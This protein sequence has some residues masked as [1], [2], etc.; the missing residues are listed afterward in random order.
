LAVAPFSARIPVAD[1]DDRRRIG[2]L[3]RFSSA[4]SPPNVVVSLHEAITMAAAGAA[5][6]AHSASISGLRFG[7]ATTPGLTQL[8]GPLGFGG[9][10]SERAARIEDRPKVDRNVLQSLLLYTSLSSMTTTVWPWPAIAGGEQGI[11]V[12]DGRQIGRS[13]DMVAQDTVVLRT[14]DVQGIGRK[15]LSDNHS[16]HRRSQ[17]RA[18]ICDPS[19]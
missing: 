6:L 11:Q 16:G 3:T 12:V 13:D 9:V 14:L 15:S 17:C 18:G 2:A 1:A 5:A 8:F 7:A 10:L 19:R 4:I